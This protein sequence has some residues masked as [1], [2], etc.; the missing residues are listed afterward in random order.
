MVPVFVLLEPKVDNH[1]DFRENLD[2]LLRFPAL[3]P[4]W[5]M[6]TRL[7]LTGLP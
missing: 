3:W 2:A 1:R 7:G 6:G 4:P 5:L